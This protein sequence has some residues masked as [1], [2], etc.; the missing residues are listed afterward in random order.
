MFSN[1][2]ILFTI[3]SI[4]TKRGDFVLGMHFLCLVCTLWLCGSIAANS[5]ICRLVPSPFRLEIRQWNVRRTWSQCMSGRVFT[6]RAQENMA[7]DA[8]HIYFKSKTS[9]RFP[10]FDASNAWQMG[11]NSREGFFLGQE[12]LW[13]DL[14]SNTDNSIISAALKFQNTFCSVKTCWWHTGLSR[15]Y[16]AFKPP[17]RKKYNEL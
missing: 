13:I 10:N 14:S 7:V 5:I 4:C 17:G 16:D 2:C 3:G 12:L 1:G 8:R 15:V 6:T 11:H 9:S